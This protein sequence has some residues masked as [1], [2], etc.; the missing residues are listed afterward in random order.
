[1]SHNRESVLKS[2]WNRNFFFLTKDHR[3]FP[4]FWDEFIQRL[5]KRQPGWGEEF[6][7]LIYMHKDNFYSVRFM[8]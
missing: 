7:A 6:G 2:K 8:H 1:M 4:D 3:S 5:N